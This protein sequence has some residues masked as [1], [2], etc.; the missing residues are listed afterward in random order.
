MPRVLGSLSRDKTL[1]GAL[2]S[3]GHLG[4]IGAL[5]DQLGEQ[6]CGSKERREGDSGFF[7]DRNSHLG[8]NSHPFQISVI[9]SQ[10][11]LRNKEVHF[12]RQTQSKTF[13]LVP[14]HHPKSFSGKLCCKSP[15]F[16]R[17]FASSEIRRPSSLT[18][19]HKW[20]V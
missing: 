19:L 17:D 9:L 2:G 16:P 5:G 11:W 20:V 1:V 10:G 13:H 12:L 6:V 3:P 8:T 18:L 14:Y 15:G 7:R 4:Q